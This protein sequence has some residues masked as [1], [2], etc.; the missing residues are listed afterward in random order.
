MRMRDVLIEAVWLTPFVYAGVHA[1]GIW[2]IFLAL[3]AVVYGC[4]R[5][6]AR[7]DD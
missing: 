6:K 7:A 4:W 2:G 1:Y 3:L 5:G